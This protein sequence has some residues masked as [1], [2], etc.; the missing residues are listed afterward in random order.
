[1]ALSGW[2]SCNL[3]L[4]VYLCTQKG[5]LGAFVK[6]V[7][8]YDNVKN[9]KNSGIL[10]F[11]IGHSTRMT[12]D[13]L[14]VLDAYEIGEVID[15]RTIPRSRKNP[16][17]NEKRLSANLKRHKI[18]Y[19]HMGGLGGLRHALKDSIN[20]YW[21]NASFRG[22]ADYM[23]TDE[24]KANIDALI[25]I[26]KKRRV[27]LMC[28]EAV[29]WRCHR[30]LIADDLSVNGIKVMHIFSTTNS[31]QHEITKSAK[32]RKGNIVYK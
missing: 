8:R 15:V 28:A 23:Q 29:P 24:F 7:D 26:A 17:F 22:F 2:L 18:R 12:R 20:T 19:K 27:A 14:R 5:F 6:Y 1:M 32:V 10:V 13:F 30:S 21:H 16:Q 11:T 31:R 4:R 3:F 25:K 9:M